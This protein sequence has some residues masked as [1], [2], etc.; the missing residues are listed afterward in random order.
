MV[1][2]TMRQRLSS[3]GGEGLTNS[4]SVSQF[5]REAVIPGI[6]PSTPLGGV[7]SSTFQMLT[8]GALYDFTLTQP[9]TAT[10]HSCGWCSDK[11]GLGLAELINYRQLV[12][13]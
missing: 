6:S 11:T 1:A 7:S 5:L 3:V 2:L 13:V 12:S 8:K 9:P 10:T 4:I